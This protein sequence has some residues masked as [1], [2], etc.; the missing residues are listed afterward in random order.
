VITALMMLTASPTA[1]AA[2]SQAG[3]ASCV[4]TTLVSNNDKDLKKAQSSCQQ[5]FHWTDKQTELST[6]IASS[7]SDMLLTRKQLSDAGVD[8]VALDLILTV[9]TPEERKIL[10]SGASQTKQGRALLDRLASYLA[11]PKL[12]TQ[13]GTLSGRYLLLKA[14]T[15]VLGEEFLAA[16]ANSSSPK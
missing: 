16:G 12:G 11:S 14:H 13:L 1:A 6:A 2:Q 5:R 7:G 10:G 15:D 8:V 4:L 9:F 3:Q